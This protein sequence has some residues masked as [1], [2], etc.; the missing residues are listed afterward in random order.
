MSTRGDF[1]YRR[2]FRGV[3]PNPEKGDFIPSPKLTRT[4]AQT[5]PE[6]GDL[7]CYWISHKQD[8]GGLW[9]PLTRKN[10]TGE[11]GER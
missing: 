3:L 11:Q 6:K 7:W 1:I 9:Q 8:K 10:V 4:F 2:P 5:Y